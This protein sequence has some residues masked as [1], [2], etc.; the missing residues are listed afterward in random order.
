MRRVVLTM[1]CGVLLAGHA[2]A[3]TMDQWT[4][5][6]LPYQQVFVLDVLYA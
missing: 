4:T 3:I 1:M 2:S 5:V 6:D